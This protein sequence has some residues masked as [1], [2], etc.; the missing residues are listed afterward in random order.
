MNWKFWEWFDKGEPTQTHILPVTEEKNILVLEDP[1]EK[2]TSALEI[3]LAKRAQEQA[4][5]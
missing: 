5:K 1:I 3:M 4:R 2:P